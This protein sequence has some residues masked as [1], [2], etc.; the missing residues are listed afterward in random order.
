[1]LPEAVR[2]LRLVQRRME[3]GEFDAKLCDASF[4]A[5]DG[6]SAPH[7]G[8]APAAAAA[9]AASMPLA[10]ERA[11]RCFIDG[12]GGAT[13]AEQQASALGIAGSLYSAAEL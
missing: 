10:R 13:A 7:P 8:R 3:I 9:A 1:M 11:P 6:R 2:H 5:A 4:M 12:G